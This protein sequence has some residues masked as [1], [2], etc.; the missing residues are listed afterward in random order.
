M[1]RKKKEEITEDGYVNIVDG[2]HSITLK[3]RTIHCP[4]GV[5]YVTPEEK[6][7]IKAMGLIK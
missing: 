6:E 5:A 4:N 1:A 3:H 2:V 7:T